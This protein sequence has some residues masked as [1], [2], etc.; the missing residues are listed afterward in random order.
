MHGI[1]A[2]LKELEQQNAQLRALD[3]QRVDQARLDQKKIDELKAQIA[4][5]EEQLKI[6][7]EQALQHNEPYC[8]PCELK[9]NEVVADQEAAQANAA[10]KEPALSGS[11]AID[12][13]GDDKKDMADDGDRT[14]SEED[15]SEPQNA[16]AGGSA[17]QARRPAG[18][19]R[20][21]EYV[22]TAEERQKASKRL[23]KIFNGDCIGHWPAQENRWMKE[24]SLDF[25]ATLL[26]HDSNYDDV[27]EFIRVQS[28]PNTKPK[29]NNLLTMLLEGINRV[30]GKDNHMWAKSAPPGQPVF[31]RNVAP[32]LWSSKGEDGTLLQ[33]CKRIQAVFYKIL[34]SK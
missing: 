15:E 6:W 5:L 21:R 18:S 24:T 11:G 16:A 29:A 33:G 1:V 10:G 32:I 28:N 8:F 3:A 34:S 25:F 9:H 12:L 17:P 27:K 7:K 2:K 14:E 20:P 19:K 23:L 13:T 26:E 30:R 22:G 31:A 4:R